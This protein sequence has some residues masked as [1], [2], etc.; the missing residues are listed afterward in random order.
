MRVAAGETA[1]PQHIEEPEMLVTNVEDFERALADLKMLT[2]PII[3]DIEGTGL[4]PHKREDPA[5]MC[6]IAVARVEE[7]P[8][9]Y[10]SY[11]HGDGPNLPRETLPALRDV[12][13]KRT[14]IGHNIGGYDIPVLTFDGFEIPT[15]IEDTIIAAHLCF[16]GEESF[17]LKT[18][19]VKYIDPNADASDKAL[20]ALLKERKLGK[21]DMWRLPA[22]S[23]VDDA[24]DDLKLPRQLRAKYLKELERWG[25]MRLYYEMNEFRL[26]MTRMELRGLQLDREEVQRQIASIGPRIEETKARIRE[27]A[28]F[29]INVNSPLQLKA[30]LGLPKTDKATLVEVMHR[31]QREDVRLL[32]EYRELFK[33]ES[34]YFRP[35][36]ELCDERDRLHT[37]YKVH[38]T[39]TGRLSSSNPN[40]QN[41]SRDQTGRAYSIRKCFTAPEGYFLAQFDYSAIEPRIA[42]HYS[43]DKVMKQAFFEGKDFHTAVARSMYKTQDINKEQRTTAKTIGLGTLY[44]MGS[45]K[46]ARKLGL[47]HEKLP[48]G[49][50]A[51]CFHDVW[52]FQ[53]DQLVQLPCHLADKEFCTHAG[54]GFRQKFYEGV[55]ELEPF[56][57]SVIAKAQQHGYVR[58]PLSGRVR[59]FVGPRARPYSAPN[60]L[61]QSTAAEI[62]RKAFVAL[63]RIFPGHP[64]TPRAVLTVHD[65]LAWEIPY[66]PD[67]LEHLR[68]IKHVMETT[69]KL[70]VPVVVDVEIGTSL[71]NLAKIEI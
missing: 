29:D 66:G 41:A 4:N 15:N 21:G 12:M 51:P 6:G 69:T 31:D 40:L 39:V 67:A 57:K 23:V 7:G 42:A 44:G 62:L 14:W 68:K 37:S 46:A 70:S 5:R 3:T 55:P 49:T 35:F 56:L 22:S 38:G 24:L 28:G 48:D 20:R 58:N 64:G 10:F 18:L 34:T 27:L 43:G 11:G 47:R 8:G 1:L 45:Y 52:C 53:G 26:A 71:G 61:I 33:A 16:E 17:A 30:W 13:S 60:A 25:L 32:L 59:R 54:K 36:L 19:A 50:F 65:S 63:D 2:G 9:Y